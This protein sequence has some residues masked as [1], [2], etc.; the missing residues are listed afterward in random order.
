MVENTF[1]F[2]VGRSAA[3]STEMAQYGGGGFG[4]A[5]SFICKV[6]IGVNFKQRQRS[7][8][9]SESKSTALPINDDVY[10]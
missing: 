1:Y 9:G 3:L 5:D 2:D 6:I 4:L 8:P 10:R 7:F